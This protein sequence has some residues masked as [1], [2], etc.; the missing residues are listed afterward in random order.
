MS[1]IAHTNDANTSDSQECC[2]AGDQQNHDSLPLPDLYYSDSN[3]ENS[4]NDADY[5]ANNGYMILSQDSEVEEA[6][7]DLH[8]VTDDCP[9]FSPCN[10]QE[11][12]CLPS[13]AAV[14]VTSTSVNSEIDLLQVSGHVL[15]VTGHMLPDSGH[16]FPVCGHEFPV[17]VT[18]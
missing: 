18:C 14:N 17:C 11:G 10:W 4:D 3:E 7:E 12:A 6:C 15:P 2:S 13:E 16:M 1:P 5:P 9:C 8:G